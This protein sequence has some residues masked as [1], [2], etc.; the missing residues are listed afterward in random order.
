MHRHTADI[1]FLSLGATV[2]IAA[3]VAS[4]VS[5]AVFLT[6]FGNED[7]I[8]ET[9]TAVFLVLAGCVLWHRVMSNRIGLPRGALI[10]GLLYGLVYVWAG[11]EE[12]SWGQRILGFESPEY[13]QANNDQQ[14]FTFHN[15]VVG[16]VKLD[17]VIFGPVLSYIILSY[18]IV[19][20]LLWPRVGWVQTLARKMVIPVPRLHHAVYALVVTVLI[21]FLDQS[22]RWEVYECIFALLSLA[23]F[24][25]PANPIARRE[26]A[27]EQHA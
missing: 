18:L 24:I 26:S 13:F 17:E 8:T 23:I 6:Y 2:L 25:H 16:S 5:K 21:V 15:L 22:R 7:S 11:G 14:E 19:L 9:A 10:L 3:F 1:A 20:P 12:I 27:F 4:G